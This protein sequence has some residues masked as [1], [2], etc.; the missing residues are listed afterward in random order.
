MIPETRPET[1]QSQAKQVPSKIDILLQQLKAKYEKFSPEKQYIFGGIL[2]YVYL[3][4][5]SPS[6]DMPANMKRAAEILYATPSSQWSIAIGT[7]IA[8]AGSV[9]GARRIVKHRIPLYKAYV[10][11]Y[12]L[13]QRFGLEQEDVE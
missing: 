9:D 8:F 13:G 2:T 1:D 6:E 7:I 5:L 11:V 4:L 12:L 10:R 3:S